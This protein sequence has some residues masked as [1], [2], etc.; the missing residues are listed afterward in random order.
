M[1]STS[2][3]EITLVLDSEEAKWLSLV[4]QNPLLEDESEVDREM[5]NAFWSALNFRGIE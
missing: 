1:K 5:R 2:K 3:T 4:V